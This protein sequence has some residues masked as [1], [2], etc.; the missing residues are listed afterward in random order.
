MAEDGGGL[1]G[2][3][4]DGRAG[5]PFTNAV[6]VADVHLGAISSRP[7]AYIYSRRASLQLILISL[8]RNLPARY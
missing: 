4:L 2:A 6:A 8:R 1:G 7:M 3:G 5:F